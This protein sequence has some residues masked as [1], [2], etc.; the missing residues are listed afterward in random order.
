MIYQAVNILLT[1]IQGI[2][3]KYLDQVYVTI[4]MNILP[5]K[6]T[7]DLLVTATNKNDEAQKNFELKNNTLFRSSISKFNGTLTDNAEDLDIVKP[8]TIC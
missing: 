4:V 1:K 5:V 3:L 7:I 6:G 8:L 2:K